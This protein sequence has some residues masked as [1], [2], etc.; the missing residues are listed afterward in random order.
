MRCTFQIVAVAASVL[1]PLAHAAQ[2][3]IV[4]I[5]TDDLTYAGY[6]YTG[7]ANVVTPHV[8]QLIQD[9]V[10]VEQAYATHAVSAP[11]R[12]AL[13]TGRYQSRFGY[14]TLTGNDKEGRKLDYGVSTKEIFLSEVLAEQGYNTGAFGK[15]HLGVNDHYQPNQRGFDYFFGFPGGSSYSNWNRLVENGEP[16]E[17]EGYITDALGD[18]ATTFIDAH[19]DEPFFLYFAP[20]SVHAP[21]EVSAEY[22]PEGFT[23]TRVPKPKGEH[24][25]PQSLADAQIVYDAMIVSFDAQVGKI[26]EKLRELGLEENTLVI[27]TNDNGGS[28]LHP[29]GEFSG[30]KASLNEGGLRMPFA[31]KWPAKLDAGQSYGDGIVSNLDIFPTAV[32]A[33]GGAMPDDRDYDGTDLLP[34]LTGQAQGSPRQEL[35]WRSGRGHAVRWNN[36]KLLWE[37]DRNAMDQAF[38]E[39]HDRK[40]RKQDLPLYELKELY[41]APRLYDLSQDVAEQNDLARSHPEVVESLLKKIESF[42]RLRVEDKI[43]GEATR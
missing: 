2:P 31:V 43:Q 29:N 18:Q 16:V 1:A 23:K 30:G 26:T 42:D 41:T 32:A 10:F 13:M 17:G 8:D 20:F 38:V 22:L 34:Y 33:A 28:T 3:N 37:S 40:R 27:L 35:F 12:A 11:S 14:E 4:V 19:K 25:D 21:Y 24:G 5:I 9:G 7:N 36:Y 15:W 39:R 6:S